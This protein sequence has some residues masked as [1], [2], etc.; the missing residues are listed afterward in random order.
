MGEMSTAYRILV[1]KPEATEDTTQKIRCRWEGMDWRHLAQD[2]DQWQS[3]VNMIMNFH[4][5]EKVGN[6]LIS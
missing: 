4:I 1:G 3:L 5:P 6:F 2:R